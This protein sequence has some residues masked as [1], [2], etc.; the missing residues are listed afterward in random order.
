MFDFRLHG[1][2]STLLTV[3]QN[4]D[5]KPKPEC[6]SVSLKINDHFAIKQGKAHNSIKGPTLCNVHLIRNKQQV[7]TSLLLLHLL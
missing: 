7:P 3:T 1:D 4:E 5:T 2:N 6:L